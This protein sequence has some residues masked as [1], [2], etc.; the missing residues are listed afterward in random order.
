MYLSY[1]EYLEFHNDVKENEFPLLCTKASIEL[2]KQTTGIDGYKKLKNAFP[3]DP[4]DANSI[5]LCMV[6]LIH[7]YKSIDTVN[8]REVNEDGLPTGRQISSF[9]S[10]SESISYASGAD[11]YERY[12]VDPN[13]RKLA[14]RTIVTDYLSGIKDANGVNILFM[15]VYP[16]V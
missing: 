4:D 16:Y 8:S 5:K 3:I 11:T 7:T 9:S 12:A 2:D 1:E 6:E 15:G 14:L 13:A 10:G